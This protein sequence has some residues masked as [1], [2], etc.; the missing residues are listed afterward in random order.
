MTE[1]NKIDAFAQLEANFKALKK[2]YEAAKEEI[3]EACMAACGVTDTKA[4]VY[5]D[6]F[7]ADYSMTTVRTFSLEIAIEKGY[8]T[9]EQI[10]QC[11]KGG[12]RNNLIIKVKPTIAKAA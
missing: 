10:E 3:L 11:K 6:D 7:Y 4:K 1:V 8:I 2:E 12:S 5:G 9:E